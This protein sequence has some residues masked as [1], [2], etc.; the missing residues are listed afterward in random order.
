M[1][2]WLAAAAVA[3]AGLWFTPDQQGQR[4]F[5]AGDFK[6]AAE[7]FDDPMWQGAA[8]FRAGEFKKALAAFSRRETDVGFYN[9][10]NALLMLGQYDDAAD[11]YRQALDQR[12]GWKEARDN[13][14]LAR[15]RAKLT[16]AKGGDFGD[17]RLGADKV[18][19][20]KDKDNQAG[21]DTEVA[22]DE[23]SSSLTMQS[24]W[25]RRVT[26]RPADFLKAKFAYQLQV[27]E[28][29]KAGEAGSK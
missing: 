5:E 3:W 6:G 29:A 1:K 13:L 22:G 2:A 18:V 15:A 16:E 24:L 14:E 8:W 27:G 19:F 25:L 23:A 7:A 12:P 21:Q 4:L 26:T 28:A 11:A 9:K 17:Q 10:G 20:D